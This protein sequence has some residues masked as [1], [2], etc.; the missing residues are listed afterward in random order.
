M[1]TRLTKRFHIEMFIHT[2]PAPC[3]SIALL[4]SALSVQ[5]AFLVGSL[6]V[7]GGSKIADD[8]RRAPIRCY[9]EESIYKPFV[10]AMMIFEFI[11]SKNKYLTS[12]KHKITHTTDRLLFHYHYWYYLEISMFR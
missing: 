1:C 9:N 10:C 7:C 5:A 4:L 12:L 2:L 8:L 6:K 3:Y 11:I